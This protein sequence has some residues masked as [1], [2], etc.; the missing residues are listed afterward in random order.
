MPIVHIHGVAVRHEQKKP[1][2]NW[3]NKL[4]ENLLKDVSWEI[5]EKNL[6][7]YIAPI[8]SSD[9]SKVAILH[10]YWGDLAAH[11]AWDGI[12]CLPE[13]NK[14]LEASYLPHPLMPSRSHIFAEIRQPVNQ[15]VARFFGD[16]FCYLNS[17]GNASSPGPISRRVL[18]TLTIAQKEKLDSGEPIVVVSNSMGGQIMY[19][20]ITHFL[21]NMPEYADIKIDFW[22]SVASQVGMFEEMKLFL[23]SSDAYGKDKNNMVPF[24]DRK[25]LGAWWNIWDVDDILTYSV[26]GIIEGVDD[27]PFRVGQWLI[28][29]HVG[30]LQD[31]AFYRLFVERIQQ[32]KLGYEK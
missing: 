31:A 24:P 7:R 12:S 28:N 11:L 21:P 25:H 23:A 13:I 14:E 5:V 32:A 2:K 20:I 3:S 22:C 19:D 15:L 27:M 10:G 26:R 6:R 4:F 30:Y 16:M 9:P 29:E 1:I 17:R 8:M 18:D